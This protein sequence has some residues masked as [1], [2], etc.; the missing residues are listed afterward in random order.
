MEVACNESALFYPRYV[1]VKINAV[2]ITGGAFGLWMRWDQ[3]CS[4]SAKMCFDCREWVP[5]GLRQTSLQLTG[6]KLQ[7]AISGAVPVN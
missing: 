3:L 2:L 1:A 7:L 5:E 4:I 6:F